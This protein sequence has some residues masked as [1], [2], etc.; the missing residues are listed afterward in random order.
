MRDIVEALEP[1]L[2]LS[3]SSFVDPIV[4]K[5]MVEEKKEDDSSNN[6]EKMEME[7]ETPV[8]GEHQC[9]HYRHKKKYPNS[10]FHAETIRH[11]RLCAN[12]LCHHRERG[13]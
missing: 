3:D 1:L 4:Y 5:V 6:K 9:Y 11:R 8:K 7:I 2:E 12:A 13:A 10:A